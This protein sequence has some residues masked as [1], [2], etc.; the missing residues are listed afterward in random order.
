M[1]IHAVLPSGELPLPPFPLVRE[2]QTHQIECMPRRAVPL[3][4]GR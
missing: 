3:L 1:W 2:L 4:E